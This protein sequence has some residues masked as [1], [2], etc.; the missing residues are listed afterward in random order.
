MDERLL[1]YQMTGSQHP[2]GCVCL[3]HSWCEE[4]ALTNPEHEGDYEGSHHPWARHFPTLL[5][6]TPLEAL[7][8]HHHG[9]LRDQQ[10]VLCGYAK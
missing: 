6:H 5:L 4:E 7:L 8:C 9:S 10:E 1:V 2:V 3:C